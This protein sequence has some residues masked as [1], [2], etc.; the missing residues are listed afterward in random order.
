MLVVKIF[1][2]EKAVLNVLVEL[3]KDVV[4][5]VSQQHQVVGVVSVGVALPDV[6]A[7]LDGLAYVNSRDTGWRSPE[8]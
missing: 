8:W 2:L 3:S 1:T 7:L 6:G 5:N 4:G